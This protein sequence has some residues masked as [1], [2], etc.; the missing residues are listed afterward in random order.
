MCCYLLVAAMAATIY[1]PELQD[2]PQQN[3]KQQ[4]D[5]I[6]AS[7]SASVEKERERWGGIMFMGRR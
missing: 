1:T 5:I 2:Y 4:I 6:A 3:H 7:S